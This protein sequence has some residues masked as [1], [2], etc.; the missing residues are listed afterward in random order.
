MLWFGFSPRDDMH[1]WLAPF[2]EGKSHYIYVEFKEVSTLAMIRIWVRQCKKCF[3]TELS[4]TDMIF[5]SEGGRGG[6][7]R[8]LERKDRRDSNPLPILS[9]TCFSFRITTSQGSIHFVARKTS[10]CSLTII[11]YSV[12]KWR[13]LSVIY[14]LKCDS[15][16]LS[17]HTRLFNFTERVAN[18]DRQRHLEMYV[19]NF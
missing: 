7:H 4:P 19:Y 10:K 17:F 12:E 6:G 11:W 2:T 3:T 14:V 13:G 16:F 8:L 15:S 5:M 18:L 9:R 1:L